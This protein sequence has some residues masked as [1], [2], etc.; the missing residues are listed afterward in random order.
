MLFLNRIFHSILVNIWVWVYMSYS[1]SYSFT[2][3]YKNN[4]NKVNLKCVL[5][6]EYLIFADNFDNQIE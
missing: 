4:K 1:R 2:Y 6:I 3:K 5:L